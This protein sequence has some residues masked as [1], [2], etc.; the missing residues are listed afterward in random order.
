MASRTEPIGDKPGE[1]VQAL[2]EGVDG[3]P[4]VFADLD[5]LPDNGFPE[6]AGVVDGV[7]LRASVADLPRIAASAGPLPPVGP[8]LRETLGLPRPANRFAT[9]R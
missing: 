8:T 6:L 5:T 3:A 7:R 1:R 9:T 2:V 4:L